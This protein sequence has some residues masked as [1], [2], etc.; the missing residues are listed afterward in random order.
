[1]EMT[2]EQRRAMALA[3]ARMRAA[4]AGQGQA[5]PQ[6]ETSDAAAAYAGKDVAKMGALERGM[7]GFKTSWDRAAMGLKG[8]FTDL[9]PEDKALL[10]GGR[11]FDKKSGAAGTVGNIAFDA[12][13]SAPLGGGAALATK[14]SGLLAKT[15]AQVG[16]GSA[17][18]ALTDPE[19]RAVGAVA[20]GL[21]TAGGMAVNRV[22]GG[23]IKPLASKAA[24]ELA[25]R[26]I[27]PTI[28][29]AIGGA[30]NTTEQKLKSLPLVGDVIRKSRDRAVNEF[31]EKAIQTAAPGVTGFGDDALTAA[32]K[33]IGGQY[34][35]ILSSVPSINVN[36]DAVLKSVN[37]IIT[38]P[39]LMLN[40][41]DQKL[42]RNLVRK[43][44]IDRTPDI[45]GKM[46]KEIESALK[47]A[48]SNADSDGAKKAIKRFT[49]SW[50]E[51][52]IQ[53]VEAASEGS[54][55]S[56]READQAWRAFI[57]LDRAG[58]YRGNQNI[59]ANEVPGRFTPNS[60]RRSLEASDQT[61]FNNATRSMR[62]GNTP[63]DKLNQLTRQGEQVLGDSVPDSGTAGRLLWGAGAIGA[64]QAAGVD[65]MTMGAGAALTLPLYS[66][67]G[68]KFMLQGLEPAYKSA[69]Q[70]LSLRGVPTQAIDEVLRKYGPQ[71]VI[72]LA[73][74]AAVNQ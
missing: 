8:L 5:A 23:V 20:G 10:E 64:G 62:G 28:G 59:A 22:A 14:G 4:E 39:K 24:Q 37:D 19:N 15:L 60:L 52:L 53:S 40:S 34:E 29:Q 71:G 66:K 36:K 54:G 73:T 17:Y 21:G 51:S 46:A 27:T 16:A 50:R 63:F 57:P 25:D 12:A 67:A 70:Q 6:P 1:M 41:T 35:S 7:G 32:R 13:A 11:E 65:P 42:V 43:T 18:G 55:K 9:T 69:L 68:S 74:G 61:Q 72:A 26:G 31:N 3:A 56:L 58:S 38:D 33:Q 47:E 45:D 30:V 2:L 48:A 44:V 49:D